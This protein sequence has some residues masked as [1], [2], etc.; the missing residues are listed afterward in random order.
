[1][2]SAPTVLFVGAGRHQRR[3][4]QRVKELG[5]GVVTVD[6]N[7]DAPGL[8]LADVGEVLDFRDVEAVAEVGRRLG[9]DGVM[10][11][12]ADRA[13][14]VVA[15]AAERLGLP[16]IG[17]ETAHLMTNKIAMRR[18]LADAGVPQ[19]RFAAVRHVREVPAAAE[20][21]GF[22]AVLKPTDSAGQRGLF[23]VA[24]RGDV[25]RH[26]HAALAESTEEEA[27]LESY[28]PG[29]EVNGLLVTRD[30]DVT[31][32]TLSDRRRPPGA[33]FGVAV[34][35]VYPSTLF[36]DAL[37]EVERV[38]RSTVHALGLRDGIAY[39]QV[40]WGDDG[41]ACLIE[42]AAR[43]PAGQ[44]D[45]VARYGVGV[46]LV[47]IALRQALGQRVPE[48]LIRPERQQPMAISFLTA[49]PGPLPTGK[50]VRVSGLD[51]VQAFPGVVEADLYL[52]EGE[53]I[54]PV[55]VDGD[56]R[57]YV[58]AVG[59]TN[60]EAVER[61]EAAARLLDVEVA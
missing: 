17:T 27:I 43:I 16:G 56:R 36:G 59:T 40:I 14:P 7:P 53:T 5:A 4:I 61:A 38:G 42:V 51:R 30:G 49:S 19:P 11:F 54:R 60:L 29:L 10:T 6:R 25:E 8:A 13:V 3:A 21:V 1:V 12:A 18:R 2:T 34:A 47:Q 26:L 35:H 48:E 28:H 46:D 50:L 44:M 57:G 32:V 24:S 33:G 58:I 52:Q 41:V 23:L 15:R 45:A 9:V 31:V 55:Q 37:A 20:A 22:P 39:P